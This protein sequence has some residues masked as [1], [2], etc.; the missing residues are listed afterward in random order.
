MSDPRET[1]SGKREDDMSDA[2]LQAMEDHQSEIEQQWDDF[3][4]P[5][6]AFQGDDFE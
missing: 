5:G 3:C 1:W 2:E 6:G 4:A